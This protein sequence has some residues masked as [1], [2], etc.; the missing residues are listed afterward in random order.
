M[1]DYEHL[2]LAANVDLYTGIIYDALGLS[3]EYAVPFFV[4]SRISGWIS[5]AL[6]QYAD[7]ILIRPLLNYVGP[8]NLEYLPLKER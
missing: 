4:I 3:S 7:N 5:Q 1:K 2:G 6:E 8:E